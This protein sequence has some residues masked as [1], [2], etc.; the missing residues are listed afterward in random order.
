MLI[1]DL[2]GQVI[3]VRRAHGDGPTPSVPAQPGSGRV[4]AP[5]GAAST[6]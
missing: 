6:N 2:T 5:A 4:E 1:S 3:D